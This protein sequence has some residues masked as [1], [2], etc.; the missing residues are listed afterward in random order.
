M[1]KLRTPNEHYFKHGRIHFSQLD[2]KIQY[3]IWLWKSDGSS[4]FRL[5]NKQFV[6]DEDELKFLQDIKEI[7]TI[8]DKMYFITNGGENKE[9]TQ[10]LNTKVGN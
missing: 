8:G 7:T 6:K 4:N 9:V 1:T 3:E 2:N 10:Q 5:T